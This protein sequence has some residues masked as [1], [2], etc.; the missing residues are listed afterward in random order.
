MKLTDID[1]NDKNEVS[2]AHALL[3]AILGHAISDGT[4]EQTKDAAAV[5]GGKQSETPLPVITG[6][7]PVTSVQTAPSPP[8]STGGILAAP[9]AAGPIGLQ[10]FVSAEGAAIGLQ[11][12]GLP[13]AGVELDAHGV[14]WDARIHASTKSKKKD[15]TWTALR[16]L[17]DDTQ[18]QQIEAE[19]RAQAQGQ[20][21]GA[22]VQAQGATP[23][24]G[25]AAPQMAP[26]APLLVMNVPASLGATSLPGVPPAADPTTFEQLM[27]RV[28][29]AIVSG[30]LPPAALQQACGLL[31]LSSVVALQ[32]SPA[33]V[34]HA[35]NQ[36]KA[37]YPALQ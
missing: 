11:G 13:A 36:L 12:L 2:A 26:P 7:P 14:P 9:A 35:W 37:A 15:G 6:L 19:L 25:I 22:L 20:Q 1:L 8:S 30:V 29:Q 28:T 3:A 18:K 10:S 21:L 16:G 31:G 24:P 5:F 4:P 32:T 27:P 17:R 34:P 23:L 33:Y